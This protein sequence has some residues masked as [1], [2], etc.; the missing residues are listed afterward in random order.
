MNFIDDYFK[1]K[2]Q[3]FEHVGYNEN[4]RILPLVDSRE[5]YWQVD[6]E[7]KEYAR[8][9]ETAIQLK[10]SFK[11]DSLLSIHIVGQLSEYEYYEDEIYTQRFLPKWV[12]RGA[13]FTMVIVDTHTDGNKLLRIFD[14]SKEVK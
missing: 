10:N 6:K 13:E 2:N 14:N 4:W 12:Y 7:E 11:P 1:I 8:Y 5:F 9:A 3:I